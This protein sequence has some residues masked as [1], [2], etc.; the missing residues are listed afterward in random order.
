MQHGVGISGGCASVRNAIPGITVYS[1]L[2]LFYFI[3]RAVGLIYLSLLFFCSLQYI[4]EILY[5]S[6]SS[7]CPVGT[8][9]N[10]IFYLKL[11]DLISTHGFPCTPA[12]N[13]LAT[14]TYRQP[15]RAPQAYQ[16]SNMYARC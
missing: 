2:L 9:G 11:A 12:K 10:L 13:T 4:V 6:Y 8:T 1:C 16:C 15:T 5:C 3:L 7:V 14:A